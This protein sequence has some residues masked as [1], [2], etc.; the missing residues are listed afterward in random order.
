MS[1]GYCQSFPVCIAFCVWGGVFVSVVFLG[2]QLQVL[3]IWIAQ[4]LLSSLKLVSF[5]LSQDKHMH[6][7]NHCG[8]ADKLEVQML[9]HG[10]LYVRSY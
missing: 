10:R 7:A 9:L 5:I 1:Q 2:S 6:K 4:K 8:A 3:F